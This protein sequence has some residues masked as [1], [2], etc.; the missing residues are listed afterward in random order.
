[1]KI[2]LHSIYD[3]FT[4]NQK[5][6]YIQ[7]VRDT[8]RIVCYANE[9]VMTINT[10]K[11][12]SI[13]ILIEPRSIL[14]GAY[15]WIEKNHQRFRY[16]FT[17]DDRLLELD[18]ARVM[19][20]GGVWGYADEIKTKDISMIS[21]NKTMCP[22]HIARKG[23]AKRLEN[24][25]DCFGTFNGEWVSTYKAHAEYRFAV[26][27]ENYIDDWWFT[28][29]ICNCFSHKTI[30]IYYGARKISSIF[31]ADGIIEADIKDIPYIV[32]NLN[33]EEEYNKRKCAVQDNYLRV[34][35]YECFEDTLYRMYWK[36]LEG[37]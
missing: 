26:V 12:K 16:I 17:H 5:P 28:E 31:N 32:E 7:W 10:P 30:P 29:K 33:A 8:Q 3:N 25:I 19:H 21:S 35:D 1:M 9:E 22:L 20:F 6:K 18:N 37:L 23:L 24:R 4:T 15:N 2:E 11:E 36:S 13:A 27:I 34:R 14:P